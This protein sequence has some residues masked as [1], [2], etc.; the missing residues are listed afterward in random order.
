MAIGLRPRTAWA[1][2]GFVTAVSLGVLAA[3][4]AAADEIPQH[5]SINIST[6][7]YWCSTDPALSG[8][9]LRPALEGTGSILLGRFFDSPDRNI[10]G[11]Y[12]N[13]YAVSGCDTSPDLDFTLGTVPVGWSD[14]VSSFQGY[15]NCGVRVWRNGNASGTYWGPAAFADTLGSMDNQTSSI[16]FY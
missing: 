16:T 6:G 9:L 4:G 13:V 12:F 11:S 10:S 5:C 14:R 2:V 1:L 15:N 7:D 3:P 8:R